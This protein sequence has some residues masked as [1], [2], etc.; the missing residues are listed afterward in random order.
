MPAQAFNFIISISCIWFLKSVTAIMFL[1]KITV[2]TRRIH[3]YDYLIVVTQV[4]TYA[5]CVICFG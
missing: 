2:Y 1:L 5:Y 4:F 3:Y